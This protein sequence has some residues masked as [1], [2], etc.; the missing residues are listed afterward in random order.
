MLMKML[1][2]AVAVFAIVLAVALVGCKPK[3]E[4]PAE[5]NAGANVGE[6]LEGAGNAIQTPAQ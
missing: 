3:E 5:G 2:K 4:A 6:A 1:G